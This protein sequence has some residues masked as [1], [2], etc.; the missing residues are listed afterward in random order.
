MKLSLQSK[1]NFHN[2]AIQFATNA[3]QFVT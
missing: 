2:K 3:V 1:I